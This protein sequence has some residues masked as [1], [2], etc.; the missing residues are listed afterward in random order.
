MSYIYI[1]KKKS[2]KCY[3]NEKKMI[4]LY[5]FSHVRHAEWDPQKKKKKDKNKNKIKS[6]NWFKVGHLIL[7]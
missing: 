1:R 7:Y 6:N 3:P 2:R 4:S 5:F